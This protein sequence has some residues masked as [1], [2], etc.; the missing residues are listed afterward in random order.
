MFYFR[1]EEL[2][3]LNDFY[4]SDEKACAVYGRRRVGKTELVL[5]SVKNRSNA[6][7]FQVSGFDYDKAVDDFKGTLPPEMKSSLLD[8]VHTFRDVFSY[9][10]MTC[11]NPLIVI[12]DEFPFL[13]RKNPDA[14]VEFQ[15]II[16][17][18]LHN[19][20]LVLI[21][22]NTSFTRSQISDDAQPLYG[23]F[24][25]ILNILP[26][27]FQEIHELYLDYDEAMKVY[28]ATGGIAQ[29]VMLF[30]QYKNAEEAEDHLLFNRNGRLFAEGPNLLMQ[31]FRDI[32][33]YVSILRSI[34]GGEKES[35]VIAKK[36]GVDSRNIN[37]YLEK[38][39]NLEIISPVTNLFSVM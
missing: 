27:S 34:G 33:S 32:T 18:G 8:S 17:H 36:A 39:I 37:T 28:A 38:L 5:Q 19:V 16:D 21:G 7:Y 11:K 1:K 24:D 3:Q 12:I 9:M 31:E 2:N 35:S 10:E 13:A 4:E 20:K 25:E 29:Y 23:R 22:S 26:F 14:P 15:W 30:K 6:I